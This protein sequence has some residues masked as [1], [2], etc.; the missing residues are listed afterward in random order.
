MERRVADNAQKYFVTGVSMI[1]SVGSVGKNVMAAEWTMQVSYKPFL[2]AV[3]VHEHASTFKNIKKSKEFGVN[4]A[5]DD[6]TSLV[7]IAGGYS[8]TEIDKLKVK[9]AFKFIKS[10]HI[11][12]PMIAG[13][14]INAECKLVA[15]KKLGDHTMI[16]GKVVSVRYDKTKK[17]LVYHTGRYNKIGSLIE[18]FRQTV[19]VNKPTFEWFFTASE[20]KFVLKCVGALLKSGI[21]ILITTHEIKNISYETI[22]Y[23]VPK[24]GSNYKQV[25]QDHLKKTGLK[26]TI[27]PEPIIKRLVLQN[28]KKIQR[29][30]FVLYQGKLES[31]L[32]TNSKLKPVESDPLLQTLAT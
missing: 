9:D 5:S 16:V 21:R 11:S 3:F 13:C 17:P 29:I 7:N 23:V 20:G 6:Q 15:M 25:I 30:N 26:S 32:V 22:P 14:I 10:K 2:I 24:K 28:K 4:V 8:R 12:A 18:P 31:G 27:K 1:T 19:R